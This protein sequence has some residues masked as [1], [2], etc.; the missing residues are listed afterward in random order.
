LVKHPLFGTGKIFEMSEMLGFADVNL[1]EPYVDNNGGK[2]DTVIVP[3]NE[4][5]PISKL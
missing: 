3:I 5:I 2:R 4:L 1:D